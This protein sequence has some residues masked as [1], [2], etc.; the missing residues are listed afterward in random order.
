M[1]A[2]GYADGTS[3]TLTYHPDSTV[4]TRETRDGVTVSY[5]Y[6]PAN[7]VV[8][9]T[10]AVA[11]GA[12]GGGGPTL[13]DAGDSLAYDEL[14]RPTVLERGRPGA[15]GYDPALAVSYPGYDLGS[16]PGSEVVG[17]RDPL[18]WSYDAW[19]RPVEV[20]LPAG[21][22]RSAGGPFAGFAQRYDTL[23]RLTEVSGLGA[24]ELSPTA[25]GAV[26]S[27]GGADRLY[28]M[29]TR[30]ALGTAAH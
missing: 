30:G 8:A 20:T 3:E 27:W 18:T 28:G 14:S 24:A 9:A 21:P 5:A 16:R 22:E 23:D 15:A 26:W 10:P 11:G 2:V 13:L 4:A 19:S 17:G 1:T 6:D 7:R 12:G 25:V 29:T